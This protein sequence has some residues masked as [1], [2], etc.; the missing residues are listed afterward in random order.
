MLQRIWEES[1]YQYD[2][3]RI[4]RGFHIEHLVDK[5]EVFSRNM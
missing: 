2:I 5:F 1:D 4:T 3:C